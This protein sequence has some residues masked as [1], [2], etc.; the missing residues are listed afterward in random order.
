MRGLAWS[1]SLHDRRTPFA[2]DLS[3]KNS[4]NSYLCFRLALLH[5]VLKCLILFHLTYM[6]F[7]R[8]THLLMCFVFRDFNVHH[9]DS[10]TYSA[11][12]VRPCELC[13]NF[14][15]QTTLLRWLTFLLGSILDLFLSSNAIIYSTMAFCSLGNSDH[16]VVSVSID[17]PSNSTGYP[18]SSHS[19]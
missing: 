7:S 12:T 5:S 1:C 2:W 14:K 6:R 18:I 15:S 9:K 11:G 13:Y 19:L 16:I 3:L 10:L 4:A 8:S 17:L